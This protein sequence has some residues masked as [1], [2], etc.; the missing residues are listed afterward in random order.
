MNASPMHAVETG[1]RNKYDEFGN[2]P[3][4]SS[5]ARHWRGTRAE[6]RRYTALDIEPFVQPVT[7]IAIVLEGHAHV[8]RRGDG[9][10]QRFIARPGTFCICPA[11]VPVDYLQ[12][13]GSAISILHLYIG[14]DQ[15][16]APADWP[17]AGGLPDPLIAEIGTA[18]AEEIQDET[19][20]GDLLLDALRDTLIARIERRLRGKPTQTESDGNRGLDSHRLARVLSFLEQSIEAS[21]S[22]ADI[23][24][25]ACLSR[26]HF[27]REFKAAI[28]KTPH[29]YLRTL[30]LAKAR[31]LLSH[32]AANIDVIAHQL[33]FSNVANFTRA[34]KR[35][36]GLNPGA[37]RQKSYRPL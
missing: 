6:V 37:F 17:Y 22:L 35:E 36:T 25:E 26:Y 18:I 11:G 9:R 4:A 7:E 31:A 1:R 12:A 19:A 21:P 28:G 13:H 14:A 23:A 10:T 24:A 32:E 34:F 33:Q 15:T 8:D 29:Q 2:V 5:A 27:L 30:R 3:L 20:G 16:R